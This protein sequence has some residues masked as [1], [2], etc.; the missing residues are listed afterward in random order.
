MGKLTQDGFRICDVAIAQSVN[1]LRFDLAPA[2]ELVRA[3]NLGDLAAE[4]IGRVER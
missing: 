2:A 4:A 3:E 1:H